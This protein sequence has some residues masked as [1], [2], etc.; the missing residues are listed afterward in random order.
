MCLDEV[1]ENSSL[2]DVDLVIYRVN[3]RTVKQKS[4]MIIT[5]PKTLIMMVSVLTIVT[6]GVNTQS[7]RGPGKQTQ[8]RRYFIQL[9]I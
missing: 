2:I 1:E 4:E 9:L 6:L 7:T 8:G 5:T 3:V